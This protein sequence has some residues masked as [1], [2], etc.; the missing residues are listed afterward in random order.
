MINIAHSLPVQSGNPRRNIAFT[1]DDDRVRPSGSKLQ[2][3]LMLMFVY[4][5]MVFICKT[6]HER[7]Y[8]NE[9]EVIHILYT[10]LTFLA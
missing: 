2:S 10:K 9:P 4:G 1:L 7:K 6:L 3:H 5:Q 8:I